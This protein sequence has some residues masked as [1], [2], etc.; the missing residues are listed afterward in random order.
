M[1]KVTKSLGVS[2]EEK[3]QR[4]KK[5][6]GTFGDGL[7]LPKRY[8]RKLVL[9]KLLLSSVHPLAESLHSL[10]P[11]LALQGRRKEKQNNDKMSHGKE[12]KRKKGSCLREN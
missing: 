3:E 10:L 2:L 6:E 5:K 9:F 1:T 7:A 12:K 4:K 8:Q 11:R